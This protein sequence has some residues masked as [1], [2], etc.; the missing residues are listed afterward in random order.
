L[1]RKKTSIYGTN[2]AASIFDAG[3]IDFNASDL[4]GEFGEAII[5]HKNTMKTRERNLLRR[6][7]SAV[8][9]SRVNTYVI[10][11]EP[12]RLNMKGDNEELLSVSF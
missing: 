3:V 2:R 7:I 8:G 4:N 1:L 5:S 11:E 9:R 10:N 12:D 6:G